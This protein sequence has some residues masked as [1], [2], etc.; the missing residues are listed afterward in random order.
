MKNLPTLFFLLAAGLAFGQEPFDI[1]PWDRD[2]FRK[3]AYDITKISLSTRTIS[4]QLRPGVVT[5]DASGTALSNQINATANEESQPNGFERAFSALSVLPEASNKFV[6]AINVNVVKYRLQVA[7]HE[8]N[9]K[10]GTT[11]IGTFRNRRYVPLLITSR[12]NA[13][14]DSANKNTLMDAMSF[15]GG[16]LNIRVMPTL[17]YEFRE[18]ETGLSLGAVADCRFL[19]YQRHKADSSFTQDFDV[20]YYAGIGF[21]YEGLGQAYDSNGQTNN[22][23]WSLSGLIGYFGSKGESLRAYTVNGRALAYE[24]IFRF[25]VAEKQDNKLNLFFSLNNTTRKYYQNGRDNMIFKIGIG[26]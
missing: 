9:I 8:W 18:S 17:Y 5:T 21:R 6:P 19:N 10:E 4:V 2:G 13:K 23:Q 22:G 14:Y 7:A 16:P 25:K 26:N 20:S 24:I 12:F 11:N 3:S 1:R 15:A